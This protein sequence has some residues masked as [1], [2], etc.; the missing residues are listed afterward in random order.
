VLIREFREALLIFTVT[1]F[2]GAWSFQFLWNMSQPRPMPLI[3]AVYTILSMTFFNPPID[4]PDA[5]FLDV[6][7]F[8]TPLIGLAILARGAADFVTLL[9]NRSARQSQWEEAVA[10]TFSDHIIVCGMGHLGIRVI[11]ELIA[12]DEEIVVIERQADS[13]RL[14]EIKDYDIPVITGDARQPEILRKAGVAKARAIIVCT[15]DD[16]VN[17]QMA[18]RIREMDKDIRIVMRMFD[19]SFARNMAD[20]F[21]ISA[22]MSASALAAPAFAGAAAGAEIIQTFK[23]DDRVL[24]MGR[25]TVKDGSMLDGAEIKQ[26][27]QELDLAL[28][29]RQT[30][31]SVDVHPDA[32]LSLVAGDVI[33]VVAEIPAIKALASTWNGTR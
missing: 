22:I 14:G 15:N 23:V 32:S 33:S 28:V 11:H 3:E 25:I 13:P 5:W 21:H 27:E 1:V 8:V 17:L 30:G 29:L 18:S 19:D 4:F 16:L 31:D 10:A 24:A 2:A 6:Y 12:L 26:V 7:F 9:F 20:S